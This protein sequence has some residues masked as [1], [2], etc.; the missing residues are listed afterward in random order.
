MDELFKAITGA[1]GQNPAMI[2]AK[3]IVNGKGYHNLWEAALSLG[4]ELR[5]PTH[6]K[7]LPSELQAQIIRN[8]PFRGR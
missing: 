5:R 4:V 1:N 7:E 2:K 8:R 6:Y 3:Y